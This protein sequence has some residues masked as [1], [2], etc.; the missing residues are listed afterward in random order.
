MKPLLVR[1]LMTAEPVTLGPDDDLLSLYDLMDSR[2]VRH[3][4]VVDE[5]GELVGLVSHR[6]LLRSAL[7]QEVDLPVSLQRDMLRGIRIAEIMT[8]DIETIE[9]DRDIREAA[10]IMLENKYGCL[11]VVDDGRLVGILTESDFVRKLAELVPPS[12]V[13]G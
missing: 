7:G 4:P 2:H 9:E 3:V 11:P 12:G 8:E 5:D 10:Q 6:D 1:D 13:R